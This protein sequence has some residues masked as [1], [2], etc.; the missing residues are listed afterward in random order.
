MSIKVL[1]LG[2]IVGRAGLLSLKEGL[3]K[4]VSE[5]NID[6]VVANG[7]G[8][9]KGFG[10]GKNHSIQLMKMGIDL[11]T[12]GEKTYFKK[13]MVEFIGTTNRILRPAN[14]PPKTP[15]RGIRIVEI[16]D[17]KFA[18]INL[19]GNSNFNRTHLANPFLLVENIIEKTKS[20]ADAILVQFHATTT[21][22]KQTMGYFLDGKVAAVIGTHSKVL[23]ADAH[24]LANGTAFITDTGRCGSSISVGGFESK[25]EIER[26]ITQIP[27]QSD[28]S[29]GV[30]ELQGAIVTL[31]DDFK[32]TN[33][34][35]LRLIVNNNATKPA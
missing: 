28:E 9:T 3:G 4:V 14:Y 32:R 7:E 15:G 19:M 29:W 18:F 1:F 23:T 8:V 22:E 12:T 20:E 25:K 13:D 30:I 5:N 27:S 6:Y 24:T 2:E 17:K 31:Q 34:E 21:A 16:K 10:I 35:P 26:F 11:I 33:I